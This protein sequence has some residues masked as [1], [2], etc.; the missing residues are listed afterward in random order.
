MGCD[1][2]TNEPYFEEH[3]MVINLDVNILEDDVN[4][5]R[6]LSSNNDYNIV[7]IFAV[8]NLF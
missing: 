7:F 5:V 1:P 3:D 2:E 8:K 6:A 4:L